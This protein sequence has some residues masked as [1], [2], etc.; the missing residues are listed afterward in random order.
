VD[1][2]IGSDGTI[3]GSFSDGE[4]Q[5][6]GQVALANFA[7][8]NGLQLSGGTNFTPTLASGPATIGI[9]GGR[10]GNALRRLAGVVERGYCH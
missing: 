8:V 1:F 5:A 10:V 2:S 4:T 9:P 7:N 3:T 6:L